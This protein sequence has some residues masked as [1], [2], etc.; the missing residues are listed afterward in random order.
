[1]DMPWTRWLSPPPLPPFGY[2]SRTTSRTDKGGSM[3]NGTYDPPAIVELGT[4]EELTL[5]NQ[6]GNN[7]DKTFPTGT[8]KGQL[9]FS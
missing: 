4:V 5:G 9:T 7:L 3:E 2:S 6:A 1:M 8:P